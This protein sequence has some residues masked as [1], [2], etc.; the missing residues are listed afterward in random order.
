MDEIENDENALN[1]LEEMFKKSL[2]E[3]TNFESEYTQDI[4][5]KVD[6][7]SSNVE[8]FFGD[9]MKISQEKKDV[10]R[11]RG[12]PKG[13][14]KIRRD[15]VTNQK[16]TISLSREEKDILEREAKKDDRSVSSFIKVKL[17]EAGVLPK[18]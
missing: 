14:T 15:R 13:S 7:S 16:L 5:I 11:G 8:H 2:E 3:E 10:K 17:K 6:D 18:K 12:R 9:D 4:D 1:I